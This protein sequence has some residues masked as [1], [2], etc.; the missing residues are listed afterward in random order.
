M[1]ALTLPQITDHPA[2]VF[3]QNGKFV[4]SG[5]KESCERKA[6]EIKGVYC[7][8]LNNRP[9]VRQDFNTDLFI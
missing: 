8:N 2:S 5:S 4:M 9:V 1:R 6:K 7:I 3:D